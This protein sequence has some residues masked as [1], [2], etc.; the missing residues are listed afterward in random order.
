MASSSSSSSFTLPS[1]FSIAVLIL[2]VST[3]ESLKS[4]FHPLD[5]L[6][7]LPKQVSWPILNSLYGAADLLPTF[8]GTASPGN[9]DVKWKGACFYENTAYLEFHNKSGSEF[10]GGTL[11]IQADKAHSWTCMDL[12]VFAT[13][14][15]VTWTWYFI[16]RAH[17]VEFPEWD[18]LA[19]YEYVK[20]KGVSIFLMHAGM[21]GTLQALWDVFPLFTNTGWGESSNLAFLEKHMGAKF[22][23]RPEPWVTNVTTDQI[24]S[25][26]M[27][28]ISKIRGRWGGFETLEKWVSGAYAG[29]SAVCLRDSEGKLWVGES[30]NENEKGEDVIAILPW[31]EWWEF[32]LT[33]DDANPQIALL[34][35][36]PDVRAKF[37]VTAAWEYARS[38]EGKPYGY[39]NLIFSWID[40][41]T[42]NYPPPLDS[43]LVASFMTV[44]SKMQP[45]YA[46]NMWNEALNKRLGTKGLD[47]SDVLVEVEK[48]G[49]SFDK[50]LAI[51]EQDDWIYSDGKSTS[52][53]AFILEMYKE[54]G[55][56]GSLADSIQVTEFTLKDAYMLN[57]FE[58]NASRLPKWCND[59]DSVKLPYC[60]I[61]G[62]YRLQLPGYNTMEPYT[63]MNEQCPSLPPKLK[64]SIV[65]CVSSSRQMM[66]HVVARTQLIL[67]RSNFADSIRCQG[68]RVS[69]T[70]RM[71]SQQSKR[72]TCPS[73][74]KPTQ[75]CLCNR[76]RSPP[77]DNQVSVTILQHSLE[78]KHALNST[79]IA[80]L[81]L[82]NVTVTTVCDV[83]DEAE[84]LI[85]V[86]GASLELVDTSKLGSDNVDNESLK[87][88]QQLA[89]KR[90]SC[91][92]NLMRISMK[93]R[94]VISNVST[95]LMEDASFN[96][97][98]A[99][100][101]AMD[102]LAKGFVVTKFS[103]GKEEFELEVPPGSALL[104]PSEG[105]VMISDL[106]ERDL[107]VRNLIVLDGTWSKARRMY[108]E[109][110]WLK[111]LCSHVKLEI[112]G[113][114]LYREVR[115]Q[116]REGCLSTI[117][118]IVHAMKEMGEDTEG[119]DS[120]LDVFESMV[121]DQR[122]CK[123]ENFG[124]IL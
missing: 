90:G 1:L 117:E 23:A 83:H 52:C 49:S 109:N 113:A 13:P 88:Y 32:E 72:P 38:M 89:D 106:K 75:L 44:W 77:L 10:G 40:T 119:L 63:H 91:E 5:L 112:E 48:R 36:H 97:I 58:T 71:E 59:N 39:H 22:E 101:A 12:Y 33:K 107:K 34:P 110:P 104:F 100:P 21:L 84:F 70:L 114:S 53:I 20:N 65:M 93:K 4:P 74:A 81:G 35:L 9:D 6:P 30:G 7:L 8:I 24:Q 47:L 105:S 118:S 15:R 46:A 57:F 41:V 37:N 103:E 78:R 111:L 121:G 62:K 98:L 56:F 11:H 27:L 17:T 43:H 96:G 66:G 123:D 55:L 120:M 86:K 76:I 92:E 85:R 3:A 102:V 124:K 54:A 116:P 50:L 18:G 29:H 69:K 68:L 87:L 16:S 26:D 42:E 94:G 73:C 80:R 67:S 122:R 14:Y 61:L 2:T 45:D 95:S 79:R 28:A 82:K 115:R 64:L 51:P 108:V 31:E 99:S 25:G 19:E 60:Q